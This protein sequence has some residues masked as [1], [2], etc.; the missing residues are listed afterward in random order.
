MKSIAIIGGGITRLTAA[1]RLRQKNRPVTLYEAGRRVGGVIQ[2]IRQDGYLAEYGPNTILE[3]SPKVGALIR[4]LELESRRL[5]SDPDAER[6]YLVR[7]GKL[8]A[9]PGSL[10]EFLS[11]PLFSKKAKLRLLAEPF[12]RRA[13]ADREE[14]VGEFVRRRLG[15]EFLDYAINPFVA[16]VYAGDPARLS[17]RHAFPKL[18]ALEQRYGS[19]I[20]G[21]ILGA[22]ER[23]RRA[24][25]SKQHAKKISFDDGL[26]VLIDALRARLGE[27]TQLHCA[28]TRVAQTPEGW[29]LTV[30]RDGQEIEREHAAVLFAGTADT[31]AELQLTTRRNVDL[32]PLGRIH[33]PPVASVVLGFRREDVAHRL[34]GLGLL[35]PQV[36]GFKILGTLFSSSLFANRAPAG[37]VT[38]TT[39]IGGARSP[40]LALLDTE[41]LVELACRDLR[42]LLGVTGQPTFQHH[43]LFRRAIPQY[44]V[45]YGSCKDLMTETEASAPGF[46]LAGNYRDGVS[47]SDSIVSGHEAAERLEKYLGQP[48]RA[49][50]DT[51]VEL[52]TSAVA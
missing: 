31:L 19:L 33:Y 30:R 43:I 9:L 25:V 11:T 12:I 13:P 21:Q 3:T 1:L 2:S 44:E 37:H 36:E 32:G 42:R 49:G 14:S 27:S 18:H 47:L 38:L 4:D 24:E 39:Y 26:Q 46:F 34:D 40:E 29:T 15:C 6:R 41:S 17:V 52:H 51:P 16:G 50:Q 20:R 45:G 28:I 23:K 10:R 5:Y 22:G 8:L 48:S 7:D 35:V